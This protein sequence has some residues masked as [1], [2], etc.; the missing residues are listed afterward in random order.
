[1]AAFYPQERQ[2]SLSRYP[3]THL[4]AQEPTPKTLLHAKHREG[5]P[6]GVGTWAPCELM[7]QRSSP[8]EG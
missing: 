1:M 7:L 4:K 2:I 6:L 8:T 5:A 3:H